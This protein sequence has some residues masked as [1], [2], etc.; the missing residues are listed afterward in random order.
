MEDRVDV[1][2]GLGRHPMAVPEPAA[3]EE[4]LI[5]GVEVGRGELLERDRTECREYAGADMG[6]VVREGRRPEVT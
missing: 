6:A 2:D 1:L 5:E 3:D 4:R